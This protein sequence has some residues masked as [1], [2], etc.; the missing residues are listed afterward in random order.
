MARTLVEE[1]GRHARCLRKMYMVYVAAKSTIPGPL[2][3]A[4]TENMGRQFSFYISKL[5]KFRAQPV[6]S[7]KVT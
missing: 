2:E 5:R 7:S 6:R 4:I 1:D 3:I